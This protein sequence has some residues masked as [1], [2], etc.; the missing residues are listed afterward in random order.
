M[1]PSDDQF[2]DHTIKAIDADGQG[3]QMDDG[4]SFRCPADSPVKP[5]VGMKVR[6]YGKGF[7]QRIRGMYLDGQKVYYRTETEDQDHFESE[8][9]GNTA[10]DWLKRWDDGRTVWS[11]EMGGMGPGYEQA[12]QVTVVEI[13]RFMLAQNYMAELWGEQEVLDGVVKEI[14]EWSYK[15]PEIKGL[16]L[17]GAQWGA[18][19][20]LA[21]FLYKDGPRKVLK[22]ERVKDRHIQ[23]SNNW[24][25]AQAA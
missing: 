21:R 16:G 10:A 1:Y 9:Y 19:L 8:M 7:G 22:D 14:E 25:R 6:L 15:A 4:W 2:R 13:L 5:A 3:F 12:I 23:V 11:I 24:P 20:S 17:S 18:A